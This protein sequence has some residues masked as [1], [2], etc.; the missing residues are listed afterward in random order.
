MDCKPKIKG[1]NH[2]IANHYLSTEKNVKGVKRNKD[3]NDGTLLI[4]SCANQK[5]QCDIFE[6]LKEKA[7]TL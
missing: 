7:D 2:T 1:K 6:V 3:K 5:Q 4:R